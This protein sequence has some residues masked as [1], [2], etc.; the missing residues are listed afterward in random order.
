MKLFQYAILW[1]PTEKQIEDENLQSQLIVDITTVL[2]IDEKRAL[3]IAARAI[4]EKYLTQLAQVE[5]ALRPF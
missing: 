2:A 5:V 1:H 4:P 3:L